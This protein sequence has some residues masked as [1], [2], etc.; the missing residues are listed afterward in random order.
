M[1]TAVLGCGRW[2]AFLAWYAVRSGLEATLWG[3]PGSRA[4]AGLRQTGGN[5]YLTLPEDLPLTD[6]LEDALDGAEI[7]FVAIG[8]QELRGFL[9]QHLDTIPQ[10]LPL[11]LCM[12]GLEAET[13][14]R[15]TQVTQEELGAAQ[16]L[17]VLV[18]PGHVQHF[19]GGQPGCMLV[20]GQGPEPAATVVSGLSGELLRLYVGEDLLGAE[21][22]AAAKNVIGI[23]AGI[24]DG[25]GVSALKGALMT[26]GAYEVARL[27]RRMGG[28]EQTVYGLSHLGDYEATLFSP[29]SHNRAYGE[30]LARGESY[31]LLA[32]GVATADALALLAQEHKVD[33]PICTAVRSV[34]RGERSAREGLTHLFDRPGRY[35][36]T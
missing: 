20:C 11:V 16:P 6:R 8:A 28:H 12:K 31:P 4:L 17:A 5:E 30:A 24:L 32:E 25:L 15:L 18:G 29:Y 9:R 1:K 36:F 23:A 35:E 19:V 2:G 22:G 10:T 3:R 14:K 27:V 13:G 34:L 26:R 21:V 7:A 33:L